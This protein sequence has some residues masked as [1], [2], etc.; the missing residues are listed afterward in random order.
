MMPSSLASS[1]GDMRF[2]LV[3]V[4]NETALCPWDEFWP[5]SRRG[6]ETVRDTAEVT[7]NH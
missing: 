3:K 6:S 7:I 1:F 2:A 4:L 5:I